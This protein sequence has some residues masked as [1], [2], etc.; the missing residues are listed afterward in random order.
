MKVA[1]MAWALGPKAVEKEFVP[2]MEDTVLAHTQV[3]N[4]GE[5]QTL[6]FS[7]SESRRQV[8]LC[9]YPAW[10]CFLH[11]RSDGRDL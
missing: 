1:Q 5:K 11:E 6:K 4:P 8:S 9:L 2:D 10:T 3:L 7:S